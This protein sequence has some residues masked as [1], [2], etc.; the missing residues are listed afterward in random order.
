M[1]FKRHVKR[2]LREILMRDLKKY[3]KSIRM[4]KE[5]YINNVYR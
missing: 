1:K 2:E 3:E 5:E 4:T